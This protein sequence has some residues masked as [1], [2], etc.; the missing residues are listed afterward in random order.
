M[1]ARILEALAGRVTAADAVVKTDDT[2]SLSISPDGDTR[3][4]ASRSQV[5][6]LRVAWQ[7]RIGFASASGEASSELVGRAMASATS[8]EELDLF[9]PAAAPLPAVYARAPQAAAADPAVLSGLARALAERLSRNS[10]RVEAWAERSY[11]SVQVANT[12]SVLAGYEVTLAGVGAVV[13]SIGAGSAPPCRVHTS[14]TGLPTLLDVEG[15]VSEVD[16]RLDCPLLPS[17]AT[18]PPS[19]PVCLGPRA[20]ATFLRP[21]RAAL[22]GYEAL[23]GASPFRGRIGELVADER[24][25]L[26]DDPLVAGRPGT[27]PVDDD[28]VVSRRVVLIEHGRLMACASDLL[29]GARAQVPSTGHAWRLPHAAPRVGLTN[30]RIEPGPLGREALLAGMGAGLLIEDL[31]WGAGANPLAGT[32]ALRAPWSYLV[33]GGTVWG[34]LEGV[35]LS[36]NIF[37]AL[38]RIVEI[39]ADATWIG[40]QCLPSI[41]VEGLSYTYRS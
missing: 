34:R 10:R 12:R 27:R 13:E 31:D 11:G 40:A 18:P 5:S 32:I 15:L 6:H 29:V 16:R 33:E 25:S 1:I 4:T 2:L 24:F 3:V 20:V 14:A 21:L 9:L 8:G 38:N 17:P 23:L 41:V 28:G 7:G 30:L 39:G 37:E 36:G 19:P 22:T 35:T 26:T